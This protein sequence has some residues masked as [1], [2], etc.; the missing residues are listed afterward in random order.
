VDTP[1]DR[2]AQEATMDNEPLV[3]D[4][5]VVLDGLRFHYRDW[6]DP[7]DPAL[8]LLHGFTGNA[9]HWDGFAQAMAERYRVLALDQRGHGETDWAPDQ[10]Y[11]V[12][13]VTDDFAA[14]VAALGLARFAVAG[15]SFGGDVAVSFAAA[16]PDQVERLVLV[17]PGEPPDT[18]AVQAQVAAFRNLP[19]VFDAPDEAVQSFAAAGLAPYAPAD[20]LRHWVRTGLKPLADGRWTWCLD[21]VLQRPD[22]QGRER[23][24]HGA[25]ALWRL[26]EA[27]ACPTLLVRGAA[28][29]HTPSDE[30]ER[31]AAV[32]SDARVVSIPQAG[33][34]TPLDNPSGFLAVVGRFL[35]E[36][37]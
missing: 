11:L 30:V 3:R 2:L 24:T 15:F 21:P 37:P 35:D 5:T 14:F 27:V 19:T 16:H 4:E 7:A 26:L 18:P 22:P 28:T 13:R 8:V 1:Y 10:D 36:K 34:W 17:E 31:M 20:E 12:A 29:A 9:R 25:D 32:M 6:G 23:L 33:H